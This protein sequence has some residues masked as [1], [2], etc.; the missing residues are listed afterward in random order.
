MLVRIRLVH[1]LALGVVAF[2]LVFGVIFIVGFIISLNYWLVVAIVIWGLLQVIQR[3]G[4][5]ID[6]LRHDLD[7]LKQVID[8]ELESTK[9]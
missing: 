9:G 1:N 7:V 6:K 8:A 4:R 5:E 2:C 3:Q